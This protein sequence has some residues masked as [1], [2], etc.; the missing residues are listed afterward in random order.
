MNLGI[1]LLGSVMTDTSAHESQQPGTQPNQ[2]RQTQAQ[3]SEEAMAQDVGGGNGT[4]IDQ[5]AAVEQ[6]S[7][8]ST[9]KPA[10]PA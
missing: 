4:Q 1:E 9:G 3:T 10:G 8:G 7:Y 5:D 2:E 6:Q